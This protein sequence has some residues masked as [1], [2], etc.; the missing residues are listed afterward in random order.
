M[1]LNPHLEKKL[2]PSVP[3]SGLDD[4]ENSPF[5]LDLPIRMRRNRKNQAIRTMLQETHLLPCHLIAPFFL[6]EGQKKKESIP[7]MPKISRLSIDLAIEKAKLFHEK[8]VQAVLLFPVLDPNL[9]SLQAEKA[10]DPL[11]LIPRAIQEFKEKI[12]SLCVMTDIALDPFT[13]HG[14]DGLADE[15]EEILNDATIEV[16]IQM[17]LT[18]ARSGVDMIAPSDMM[19]GRVGALRKALDQEGFTH[20]SILSYSAKYA[21]SLYGPFRGAINTLLSFGNKKSYQMDPANQ[22]EALLEAFLD[23]EEGADLLMVKPATFYLDVIAKMK[24]KSRRPIVAYHV[25][26]EYSMVMAAEEKGFLNAK[27]IF[28]EAL[29]SIKRAGADLIV[30]YAIDQ[31]LDITVD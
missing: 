28:L 1:N 24:E 5:S 16:L 9:R 8:G 11:G 29:L 26:G 19:D 21:S 6:I 4:Q 23:E 14:H 13:S 18:H 25:S 15:N 27:A 7:S 30:T 10:Y 17:A 31:V 2:N 22:K 20:V 12:P 3:H